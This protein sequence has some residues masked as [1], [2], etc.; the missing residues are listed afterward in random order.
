MSE[1]CSASGLYYDCPLNSSFEDEETGKDL[2]SDSSATRAQIEALH[3][4]LDGLT[5]TATAATQIDEFEAAAIAAVQGAL[6]TP[7]SWSAV[8]VGS[9]PDEDGGWER[10]ESWLYAYPTLDGKIAGYE[11]ATRF[12]GAGARSQRLPG[13]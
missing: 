4:A 2:D 5:Y 8:V 11:N 7:T 6:Q 9:Q 1:E 3:A 12:H 13:S 10:D